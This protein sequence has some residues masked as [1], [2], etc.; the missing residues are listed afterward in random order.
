M[1][2][3]RSDLIGPGWDD[4]ARRHE[5]LPQPPSVWYTTGFL[6]PHVFQQEAKRTSENGQLSF[7][8]LAGEDPSNDAANRLEKKEG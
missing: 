5:Q 8:D 4:H 3:L 2:A 7:L 6:V 1:A